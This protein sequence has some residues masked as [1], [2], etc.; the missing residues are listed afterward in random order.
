MIESSYSA[1][2]NYEEIE[3]FLMIAF[4][5]GFQCFTRNSE[6]LESVDYNGEKFMDE[7]ERTEINLSQ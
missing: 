5:Q 4:A 6:L 2:A 1:H 7:L 3:E